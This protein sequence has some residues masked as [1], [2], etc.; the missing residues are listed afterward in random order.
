MPKIEVGQAYIWNGKY[1]LKIL[2]VQPVRVY[3]C[4]NDLNSD[5]MPWISYDDL[6]FEI[7][8]SNIVLINKAQEYLYA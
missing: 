7:E 4:I 1:I 3:Y 2:E 8:Y 6:I 5:V